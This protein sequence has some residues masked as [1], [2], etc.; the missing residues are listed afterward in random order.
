M[1]VVA[2][3]ARSAVPVLLHRADGVRAGAGD[4]W[5]RQDQGLSALV[6]GRSAGAARRAALSCRYQVFRVHLSAAV[7]GAARNPGV[8]RQGSALSLPLS[9]ECGGVVG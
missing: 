6:L 3:A 7:G 5:Q 9:S 2:R 4:L 1:A 8:V